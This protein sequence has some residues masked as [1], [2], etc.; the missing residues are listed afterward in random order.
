MKHVDLFN[1]FLTDTVNLNPSRVTV[2]ETSVE[3]IKNAV[4]RSNWEP[5]LHGWM[6]QGSWA[7]KT[8]IKPVD[9]GEFDADLIVF[10]QP[11]DGWDA[12][13]YIESLYQEF[14]ANST[15]K[16]MVK[17]WSHC[18]TITY[19]NDKKIDVAPCLVNRDGFTRLE[20]CNRDSNQFERTEPRQ[21]TAWLVEK[22]G[23]VGSNSFRKCTRIIKYLRDIKSRF[24]CSSVLLTTLI[25]Y[26]ISAADNGSGSF[27]DTPTALKTLIG[28]LDDWLQ[29]NLTK[30][31]VTNPFLQSE[32]FANAWTADQY[33]NFREKIHTYREWIDDAY[34]EQDRSESIAKWRRVFGEDFAS[35][36]VL[37]E[38]KSV[39]K[40][41][42]A[43]V[44]GQL[45]EASQFAGDLV[46]AIK[47]FGARI[48]PASFDRKSYMEVPKWRRAPANQ[49]IAVTIRADLHRSKLGTQFVR[50]V[51][52]LE[53]LLPGYW[54]HFKAVTNIGLPFDSALYTIHWRVTNTDEAAAAEN[55]LRGKIEKPESDNRRWEE[56]KYRG[57]HL[58][59][60]FVVK[61]RTN[62]IVGQSEAFRVMI[63]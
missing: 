21:Y 43:D 25:G 27:A 48:V 56:L 37:D 45:S 63:E 23:S 26:R 58:V 22:N 5:H 32:D 39:S 40:A 16:D 44:R 41:L 42:V 3:A 50:G 6:E 33:S 24:T 18:V 19:A 35:R 7:H 13:K 29:I 1:D 30:P 14:R 61:Q 46:D 51:N 12:Q 15:Y 20:V 8:I 2:L 59:E 31:A 28:R 47:R 9:Q 53:P 38:G 36:V 34:D 49:H 57:V 54:L 52:P 17:R 4:R 60:A 11:V 62:E 55:C 10:V